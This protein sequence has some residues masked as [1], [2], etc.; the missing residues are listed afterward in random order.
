MRILVSILLFIAVLDGAFAFAPSRPTTAGAAR[1]SSIAQ[2]SMAK[3]PQDNDNSPLI[4]IIALDPPPKSLT[5]IQV[6]FWHLSNLTSYLIMSF[7]AAVSL[8]LL[9]NTVGFAYQFSWDHGIEVETIGKMRE[10]NQFRAE[11]NHRP[12]SMLPK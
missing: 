2:R 5:P 6:A 1:G 3:F 12:P 11:V 9:L 7:G 4:K 8:G 10:M